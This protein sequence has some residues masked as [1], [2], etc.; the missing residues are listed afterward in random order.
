[1]QHSLARALEDLHAHVAESV[2]QL[3]ESALRWQPVPGVGP[4]ADLIG[5]AVGVER[6]WIAGGVAG[7]PSPEAG[8][9]SGDDPPDLAGQML[10]QL[11]RTGQISQTILAS[12]APSEWASE[13]AVA[14]EAT[15]VAGCVLHVLEEL[16]R[17]MGQIQLIC[18]L[19]DASHTKETAS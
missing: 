4:V 9:G 8:C 11:G 7:E 15:T 5:R 17:T 6:R 10:H 13:R 2:L 3:D 19:W 12:L 18:Q 14:G 16:A 1:M